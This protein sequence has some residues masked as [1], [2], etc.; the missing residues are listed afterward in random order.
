MGVL[1]LLLTTAIRRRLI[2]ICRN[3]GLRIA[4]AIAN[5]LCRI[6]EDSQLCRNDG[7]RIA[8]ATQV[9]RELVIAIGLELEPIQ[10][11]LK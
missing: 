3:Y 1:V 8:I 9:R 10:T 5:Q 7:L 2:K 6:S 4:I 11:N